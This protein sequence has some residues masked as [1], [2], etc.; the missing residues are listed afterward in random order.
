MTKLDAAA[1]VERE[2]VR[3]PVGDDALAGELAYAPRQPLFAA[4]LVNPHPHMGGSMANN[5]IVTLARVLAEAGGATLRFD[6]RGVGESDGTRLNLHESLARFWQTGYAPE[7]L[8]MIADARAALDWMRHIVDAPLV[9]VGYSFGAYAAVE[10]LDEDPAALVLI[11]PTVARHDF[12]GLCDRAAPTLVVFSDNDF[13]TP[14][15]VTRRWAARLRQPVM[16][17]CFTGAA[18]FFRGR[19]R[20]VADACAGF[21]RSVLRR[22][23]AA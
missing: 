21:V 20:A 10:A 8:L 16:E 13:A 14:A 17:R 19:E 5:L 22:T 4:A 7:D 18:H 2:R 9:V 1:E 23:E 3:I 6:Y 15:D 12:A 11:S